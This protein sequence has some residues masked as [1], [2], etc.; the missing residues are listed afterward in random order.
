MCIRSNKRPMVTT[1]L[2]KRNVI[3]QTPHKPEPQRMGPLCM[4]VHGQRN[5]STLD[6]TIQQRNT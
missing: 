5:R 6:P 2:Q 4:A 3:K 1:T